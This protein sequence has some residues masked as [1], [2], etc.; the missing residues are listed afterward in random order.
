[1]LVRTRLHRGVTMPFTRLCSW[2]WVFGILRLSGAEPRELARDLREERDA[3]DA[4]TM[5]ERGTAAAEAGGSDIAAALADIVR[6]WPGCSTSVG[7]SEE[8]MGQLEGKRF[9]LRVCVY[10]PASRPSLR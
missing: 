8:S 7:G 1:M 9:G 2:S 10:C 5:H 3:S 6:R 4:A